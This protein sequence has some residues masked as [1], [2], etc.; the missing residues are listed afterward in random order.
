MAE[1]EQDPIALLE[2]LC[3]LESTMDASMAFEEDEPTVRMGQDGFALALTQA[4]LSRLEVPVRVLHALT[5]PAVQLQHPRRALSCTQ[6]P[7]REAPTVRCLVSNIASIIQLTVPGKALPGA[8][9]AAAGAGDPGDSET[10]AHLRRLSASRPRRVRSLQEVRFTECA[11]A[12][13]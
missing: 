10:F 11:V 2:R 8:E 12:A 5:R 4:K 7:L 13:R 6:E 9:G 3:R 1:L